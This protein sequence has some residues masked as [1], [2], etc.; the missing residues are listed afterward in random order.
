MTDEFGAEINC[1]RVTNRTLKIKYKAYR[2]SF[3][4]KTK[5]IGLASYTKMLTI[6]E[7]CPAGGFLKG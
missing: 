5:N 7:T 6:L 1:H 4:K 3:K 2:Q